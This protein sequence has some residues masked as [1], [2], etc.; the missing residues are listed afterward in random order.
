M[1]KLEAEAA[2]LSIPIANTDSNPDN[3]T[4]VS[5]CDSG[6]QKV[7]ELTQ[8]LEEA[9][10]KLTQLEIFNE[11]CKHILDRDKEDLFKKSVKKDIIHQQMKQLDNDIKGRF[12]YLFCR[13]ESK[14]TSSKG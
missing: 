3:E 4:S 13:E 7:M 10:H 14:I 8:K 6:N 11:T 1:A 5:D 9:E 12:S 2:A